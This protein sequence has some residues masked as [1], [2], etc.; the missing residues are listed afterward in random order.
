MWTTDTIITWLVGLGV[1][2]PLYDG[3]GYVPDMPDE[4]GVVTPVSGAGLQLDGIADTPG[5]QLRVRGAQN[6]PGSAERLALEADRRILAAPT[7]VMV[8]TTRL[9]SVTRQ[10]GR[11][12]PM[13]PR[14]DDGGRTEY[15]CTYLTMILEE[16]L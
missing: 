12:A 3:A 15:V 8:G 7:P 10:G 11:P 9:V 2:V 5:F 1:T 4:I 16:P 6:D 13:S 14:P